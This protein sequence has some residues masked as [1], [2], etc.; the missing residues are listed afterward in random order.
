MVFS[1]QIFLFLFL[2]LVLAGYY[3]L[4]IRESLRITFLLLASLFFYA[5][6]EPKYVFVMLLSIIVDYAFGLL[7]HINLNKRSFAKIF[8][9]LSVA[10]NLGILFYFKY[11]NFT[12]DTFNRLL[13]IDFVFRNIALP[14]GISFY[15]FQGMS[16]LID[17][18]YQKVTVQKNFIKLA[19]YISFF[20]QLMAGPIVRYKD[21]EGQINKREESAQIFIEGAM[22]F[23]TGLAK[24]VIIANNM[25]YVADL[26]FG[27]PAIENTA[28][29]A[30][31]GII[32]YTFQIYFDFSGYSDM[33]IGLGKMFGFKFLENFNYPYISKTLTEFWRRWH[34]S[35]SSWF[36]DYVYIPLGGNRTGNVYVNLFIVFVLTGF[37]HGASFNFLV[38]GL[39]HGLFLVIE[40]FF[41]PKEGKKPLV[42]PP[43]PVRHAITLLIVVISWVFFRS[44]DL[45]YAMKYLGIMF[46][47]VQPENI[48][49]TLEYYLSPK[50]FFILGL[51]VIGSTPLIKSIFF[52]FNNYVF[53]KPVSYVLN[54]FLF[55]ISI[56]FVTSSS[57]NPFIYF[58]F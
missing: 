50:V 44:P 40:R 57:F 52:K 49:F 6:G 53:W 37:W 27:N 18:Y 39:W 36:R 33:A 56:V 10:C 20:P 17:L 32:C 55:F 42:P 46:G 25:G 51:A 47:F 21:I 35:L 38:W 19:F 45:S 16:Y 9:F 1:T 7:I 12:I 3:L 28:A 58:R 5:W 54:L 14:I 26:V 34:I 2:P 13:N 22:R 8:L 41:R 4:K 15:I 30:W 23:I 43:P 11:F 48:G 29:T 31:I 24:K